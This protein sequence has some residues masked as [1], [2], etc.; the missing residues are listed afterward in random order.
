MQSRQLFF[1]LNSIQQILAVERG[2]EA[3]VQLKIRPRSAG[4]F[5]PGF[6]GL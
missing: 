2:H 1:A 6:Q 3:D 5:S 4:N